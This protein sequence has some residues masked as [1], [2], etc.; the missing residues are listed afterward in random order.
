MDQLH[1][2]FSDE[3]VKVLLQSYCQGKIARADLQ[4]M[5]GIEKTRF[6]A[7]LKSYRQ[8]PATFSLVYVRTPS[9]RLS[10]QVENEVE[11]ALLQEKQIVEDR[12]LPISDYNYTALRDRLR[13]KGIEVS[14][15]T[16]IDRAKK[17]GCHNPRRKRKSH[18]R[19]IITSCIGALVQHDGSPHLWSPFAQEKW[20]L[21]TSIDDYSRKILFADFFPKETSWAHIQATQRLIQTYGLPLRYYVDS[22]R[23]FR[24]VQGRDSFWRKYVLQTDETETQWRTMMRI[25]GVGVTFAL[26][27]QAKGKVERPYRWLQDRIVRT[28]A[29][30]KLSTIEEVRSVLKE[31]VHRYNNHQL[32]STTGEIPNIRFQKAEISGNSL[33]RK[34]SVPKPYSSP[35]DIFCLREKRMV[36]GYRRISLF[37]HSIEV[38]NVPLHEDVDVH[39]VPDTTRELM[40]IRI[41][42]NTKLVHTV[43]L[44]SQGFR[45]HF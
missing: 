18:D 19:E 3:Q 8:N 7:L 11:Q 34:F 20:A 12:Q 36:N 1:R 17:L 26:S 5:L 24:F 29:Y 6:F 44:P 39:L 4:Q 25:L 30:E 40:N 31:E 13:K 2:R 37:N 28:C 38:P 27:P 14:V 33:F 45:V 41:W 43:C 9:A 32:H 10:A 21:I 42:W 35:Q 15:T 23:V 16:I 22:L